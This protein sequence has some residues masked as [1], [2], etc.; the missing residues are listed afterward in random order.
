MSQREY[1]SLTLPMPIMFIHSL[2]LIVIIII[3]IIIIIIKTQLHGKCG[4]Y[5]YKENIQ[6]QVW[7]FP[8][9]STL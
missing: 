5:L 9:L 8:F 4:L 2:A 1:K 7:I 6:C 3:I